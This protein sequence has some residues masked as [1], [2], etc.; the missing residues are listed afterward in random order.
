MKDYRG[1]P[2]RIDDKAILVHRLRGENN[3]FR[4]KHVV[5]VTVTSADSGIL[6]G[7]CTIEY[8]STLHGP[9][10]G[11]RKELERYHLDNGTMSLGKFCDFSNLMKV[12]DDI[13]DNPEAILAHIRMQGF[14]YEG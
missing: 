12:P 7:R 6:E 4:K 5:M 8:H 9:E 13:V 1:L 14:E 3:K 2:L 10:P 11:P